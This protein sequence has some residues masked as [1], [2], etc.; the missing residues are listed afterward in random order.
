MH[1]RQGIDPNNHRRGFA[2]LKSV[3]RELLGDEAAGQYATALLHNMAVPGVILSPKDDATGGPSREEA[4]AIA[5]MYKSKFGGSN[6]GAPMVLTGPMDVKPVSFSPDQ[7]DLKE[8]RRL[9]EERVSAVLGV[10]AILAGLG[11]GLDAATYNNTKELREFFTEQKLIPL[12]KTVANE[13]THQL[14]LEDYTNDD[15]TYCA[16]DL[17][18]V[19]ALAS[20]KDDTYKR[21][22][23]GVAGGWITISEARKAANLDT[24]DTH[25]IYLRPL[26]MV[27]V[28][29]ELGNQPYSNEY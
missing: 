29:I 7:M 10:P 1:I 23:M 2:P 13:L 21:M 5:K 27:A 11:A 4:E 15:S 28:P 26:N 6:R 20:D 19:R 17:N 22:N 9:P 18:E 8:L 24:D 25:D 14:L 16:Y 12:W 3:L